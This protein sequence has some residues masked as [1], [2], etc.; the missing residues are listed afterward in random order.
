[1]WPSFCLKPLNPEASITIRT[2]QGKD[3][4][5]CLSFLCLPSHPLPQ[6]PVFCPFPLGSQPSLQ[7]E[8]SSYHPA[9]PHA[10]ELPAS[11]SCRQR[12]KHIM[13]ET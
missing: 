12:L 4:P 1:M 5:R 2:R 9:A 3:L 7:V 11:V 8:V 13:L 10:K 6:H